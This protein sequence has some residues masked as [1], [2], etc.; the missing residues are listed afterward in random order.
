MADD[1]GIVSTECSDWA[2][3]PAVTGLEGSDSSG[4]KLAQFTICVP[5][6]SI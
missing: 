4:D 2:G 3:P 1:K 5:R 6:N